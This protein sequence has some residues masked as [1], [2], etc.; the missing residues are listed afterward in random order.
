[1][2]GEPLSAA[3]MDTMMFYEDCAY[4]PGWPGVPVGNE[5]GH[6]ISEALGQKRCILLAH[7]GMLTTGK[8][9]EE[10]VYLAVL[11][12]QAARLQLLA[13]AVGDIRTVPQH[14]AREAH[15]Y[16]LKQSI[17]NATFDSWARRVARKYPEALS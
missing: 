2:V 3:H 1:M 16:M 12:E 5:E 13:R 7:H 8:T 10:A 11:L 6:V 4:L 15:D 14:L 17:V 9:I